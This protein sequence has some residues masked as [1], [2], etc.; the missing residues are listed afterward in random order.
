[1]TD[2]SIQETAAETAKSPQPILITDADGFVLFLNEP[3][4]RLTGYRASEALG[5]PLARFFVGERVPESAG[6]LATLS[7]A[8]AVFV[9]KFTLVKKDGS[10][11]GTQLTGYSLGGYGHVPPIRLFIMEDPLTLLAGVDEVHFLEKAVESIREGV[12]ITDLF[13]AIVYVNEAIRSMF[14]YDGSDVLGRNITTLFSPSHG[15][16]LSY[17]I[18]S[19]TM[20]GSWEREIRAVRNDGTEFIVRIKTSLLFQEKREPAHIV[21]IIQDITREVEM[22]EEFLTANREL[23]ALNAVSAALAESIELDELLFISLV[24]V[25]EVMGMDAGVI[26]ILNDEKDDLVL[27][28][29]VRVS[30]NYLDRYHRMPVEGSVSGKVVRTGVPHLSSRDFPDPPERQA[31]LMSEGLYQVIVV[32]IRSK[33]RTLGTLSAGVYERRASITQDMKLLAS[34]G[35][36]IGMAVENS[37]VFERADLLS[38]EKDLKVGELSLLM[39]LSSALM[40]T[41]ELN[42]LLYIVLTA[43]TFGETFGFNRAAIFL[44]D[45]EDRVIAGQMGVGPTS[46]EEAGRIW[47]EIEEQKLSLF[48]IVQ[49]DYEKQG[50]PDTIQNRAVKKI[51]ISLNRTDDLVVNSVLTNRPVIVTDAATNPHVDPTMRETLMSGQE[52][53][54]VPIVAQERPLGA[55]L[56]DNVFNRKPI[57][58]EDVVLLTAFANQAGLAIQNSIVY[59]NKERINRELREAQATLLQQAKLVG[60]GEMAAEMA[61]EIRNPLVTIGGYARRISEAGS[62]DPKLSRYSRIVFGEVMKLEHTLQNILSF[63]RDIPPSISVTDFNGV[64]RDTL[65]LVVDDLAVK[66]IVLKTRYAEEIPHIEADP[67]QLRQVFLNLFYNAVQAMEGGGE[68]T[69]ITTA[70]EIGSIPCVRAEVR[71]TGPGLAPDIIGSIFKPFFTTKKSGTGLGLAITHKIIT[72]HNGNIDIINRPEGG[73]SFIVELPV[74]QPKQD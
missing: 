64:I 66:K 20:N 43:A 15:S 8:S 60:L 42:R 32:P 67:D 45:E 13:G 39:D 19:N 12:V 72:N 47:V 44:V 9:P 57:R 11:V 63:P 59:T 23:S 69:V 55:L 71:D 7:K 46:A 16:S 61:H 10:I 28:T 17:E 74:K 14:G 38:K 53:A 48:E 58:E 26:R 22:R 62:N 36:L 29:H 37:M 30:Q 41:I 73:A 18:L 49:K 70:V 54:C 65:G 33:D 56:V 24:K 27:K 31:V 35:N 6:V 3:A 25:L 34:I 1:M 52:F 51:V 21:G 2:R 68:L 5:L 50:A 4:E 40:T